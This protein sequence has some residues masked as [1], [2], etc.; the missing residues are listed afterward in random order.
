[1]DD[2]HNGFILFFIVFFTP[3]VFILTYLPVTV[4]LTDFSVRWFR[5]PAERI[6]LA[7]VG[8][9][10]VGY[11]AF[12][13]YFLSSQIGRVVTLT[14]ALA[15]LVTSWRSGW[16]KGG[17]ARRDP[18]VSVLLLMVTFTIA[19]AATGLAYGGFV[20]VLAEAAVRF[21]HHLPIDNELPR[22]FGD[23]LYGNHV[24]RPLAGDWLSSDRPPLQ[25]GLELEV[26]LLAPKLGWRHNLIYQLASM[27][28]QS[29]FLAGLAAYLSAWRLKG[30][31]IAVALV[32]CGFS[33][34]AVIHGYFVWPKLMAAGFILMTAALLLSPK[35]HEI[36]ESAPHGG[37]V[38]ATAALAMLSHGGAAFLLIALTLTFLALG[39]LPHWRFILAGLACFVALMLPWSLYQAL[40]DPPGNRL[41]KFQLADVVPVDPRGTWTTLRDAYGA[42][43]WQ[44]IIQTKWSNF[45]QIFSAGLEMPRWL[46]SAGAAL[47]SGD[48]ARYQALSESLRGQLFF[49]TSAPISAFYLGLP[50]VLL[51]VRREA[52]A[53]RFVLVTGAAFLMTA[54][55]WSLA[56]FKAGSTIT[57]QGTLAMPLMAIAAGAV[58]LYA[59]SPWLAI[60]V[61]AVEVLISVLLYGVGLPGDFVQVIQH[62]TLNPG[63]ALIAILGAAG[64]ILGC[65]RVGMQLGG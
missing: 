31:A 43:S 53:A 32:A 34:I 37:L 18:L 23:G 7:G 52:A 21:T 41:L 28:G 30:G 15:L 3:L 50:A 64:V 42:L 14:V 59:L 11:I 60:A 57:H 8:Y 46:W 10:L 54:V 35:Y 27:G 1:M 63:L 4:V 65:R 48:T 38:G 9:G 22:M 13:A 36:R 29:L 47:L 2:M 19:L 17:A 55:V 24:P 6:I 16:W 45:L 12:G 39:R 44:E 58:G 40:I 26:A 20:D 5:A 25:T 62:P 61:T 33:A 56:M 49:L 51:V